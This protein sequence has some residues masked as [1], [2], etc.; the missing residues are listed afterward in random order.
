MKRLVE[1]ALGIA[2]HGNVVEQHL[3]LAPA[4]LLVEQRSEPI[5]PI[6]FQADRND[7]MGSLGSKSKSSELRPAQRLLDR[8]RRKHLELIGIERLDHGAIAL[9]QIGDEALQLAHAGASRSLEVFTE[10][11]LIE[12]LGAF[13]TC[14]SRSAI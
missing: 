4:S 9:Q 6:V 5:H 13:I 14:R 8:W 12:G 2:R 10:Q 7:A 3:A 1:H 11:R